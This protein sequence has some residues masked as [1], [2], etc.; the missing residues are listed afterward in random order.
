MLSQSSRII[1]PQ[2]PKCWRERK[3]EGRQWE[4]EE[5]ARET[6]HYHVSYF[7]PSNVYSIYGWP[8]FSKSYRHFV[9]MFFQ[10]AVKNDPKII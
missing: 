4:K 3:K 6:K 5:R 1:G 9:V 8:L 2:E 7:S 10:V